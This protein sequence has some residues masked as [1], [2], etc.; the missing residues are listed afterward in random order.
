M[1]ASTKSASVGWKEVDKSERNW[2]SGMG[3]M[4]MG[5]FCTLG[6]CLQCEKWGRFF[7]SENGL[8]KQTSMHCLQGW[9]E[10]LIREH[11]NT[12]LGN[13]M[14]SKM[15]SDSD[16]TAGNNEVILW[17]LGG[18]HIC[19]DTALVSFTLTPGSWGYGFSLCLCPS[20]TAVT[21]G[22]CRIQGG[23][24]AGSATGLSK[25]SARDA[26]RGF[27][28]LTSSGQG[29]PQTFIT[30]LVSSQN[31]QDT[32]QPFAKLQYWTFLA[33]PIEIEG[34]NRKHEDGEIL[35]FG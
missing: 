23:V 29:R 28:G 6:S 27:G 12:A 5:H 20:Q 34:K 24:W 17:N 25:P 16:D 26:Q 21:W 18:H 11:D 2:E 15:L 13:I 1:V 22:K 10:N 32:K 14:A 30:E 31:C 19:I 8:R 3:T 33:M 7:S 35:H 9:L 4:K